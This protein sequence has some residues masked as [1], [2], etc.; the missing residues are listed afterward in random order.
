MAKGLRR[1]PPV[2]SSLP[3]VVDVRAIRLAVPD[4]S[5]AVVSQV[6]FARRFGFSAVY[7]RDW[8]Q[9]RRKPAGAAK[10]L[11]TLIEHDPAG[12]EAL[13]RTAMERP[14]SPR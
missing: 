1:L 5:D 9:G 11:L 8:E 2:A 3:R 12:V 13:I 10:L 14:G 7:V 6:E 4:R